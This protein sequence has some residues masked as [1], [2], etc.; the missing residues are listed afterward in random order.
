MY[1]RE[2]PKST[3]WRRASS[4]C[5]TSEREVWGWEAESRGGW[6]S[7]GWVRG[8]R[9]A[10]A[11]SRRSDWGGGALLTPV[12]S[13]TSKRK[14][15]TSPRVAEGALSG[16]GPPRS[17]FRRGRP[18]PRED[19]PLPVRP[20][21]LRMGRFHPGSPRG[22]ILFEEPEREGPAGVRLCLWGWWPL[23]GGAETGGESR[24]PG[25][26]RRPGGR[27]PLRKGRARRR[28]KRGRLRS[29]HS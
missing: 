17:R 21:R 22:P 29:V 26:R 15:W 18:G 8:S 6:S 10:P 12:L 13:W 11:L 3:A 2:G 14:G 7:I 19:G 1:P 4:G 24:P 5:E 16:N 20:A 9:E 25:R 28:G 27:P 23:Q